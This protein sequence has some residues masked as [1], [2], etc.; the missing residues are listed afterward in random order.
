MNLNKL[1]SYTYG[2]LW[3]ISGT[4]PQCHLSP[5]NW[6]RMIACLM[7]FRGV[8][9]GLHKPRFPAKAGGPFLGET[10]EKWTNFGVHP[11]YT[12]G[13]QQVDKPDLWIYFNLMKGANMNLRGIHCYRVVRGLLL[14]TLHLHLMA[15]LLGPG[16]CFWVFQGIFACFKW[17]WWIFWGCQIPVLERP[18]NWVNACSSGK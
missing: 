10:V 7:I 2:F 6:S 3:G 18:R 4:P 16:W 13:N 12:V 8:F 1:H 11:P 15:V 14:L 9:G 5:R 17:R